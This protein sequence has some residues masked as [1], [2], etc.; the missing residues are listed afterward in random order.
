MKQPN[1]CHNFAG[2]S[3][4]HFLTGTLKRPFFSKEI[5]AIAFGVSI[6]LGYKGLKRIWYFHIDHTLR[7]AELLA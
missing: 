5:I 4:K 7:I 2:W 6:F 3:I 1:L